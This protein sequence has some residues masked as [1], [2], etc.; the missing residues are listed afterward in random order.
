MKKLIYTSFLILFLC[1]QNVRAANEFS[2]QLLV[3]RP[4]GSWPSLEMAVDGELKG[5]HIELIQA[6]GNI[7]NLSVTFDSYPWKRAVQ[8]FKNG[9]ADAITYMAKTEERKSF[10]YFM[11][12]NLLSESPVA[13]FVLKK[14][15]S[16]IHFSG[17]FK[18]L[19]DYT[20]GS[21]LGFSYDEEF[22]QATYLTKDSGVVNETKLLMMLMT[23][24]VQVV[25]GHVDVIKFL[26]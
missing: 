25:I 16:E 23:E 14:H 13:F 10:A 4:D 12:D 22:D 20:I 26:T 1:M 24:R 8:K 5:I 6:V 11:E 17:D 19:Q 2:G 18:S 7:L 9:N 21:V 3:V 15:K